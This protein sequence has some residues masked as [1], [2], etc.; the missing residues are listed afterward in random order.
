[1]VGIYKITSPSGKIYIGQSTNI[2][3]RFKEYQ[4]YKSSISIGSK[5]FKSFQKYGVENH[6]FEIIEECTLE[7]LNEREIYW[8]YYFNTLGKTGLN[9]RLGNANGI[10]SE[11]TKKKIGKGNKGKIKHLSGPKR[12][13][14]LQYD[15]QGNF[16]R[17][18]RSGKEASV[19]LNLKKQSICNNL[20]NRTKSAYN[21]IWRYKI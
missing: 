16:I 7:Q 2:E 4:I 14:I 3:R 17:E 13:P 21:F 19:S 15:L 9:L 5:L 20:K 10:C 12:I 6:T 11:E 1:M 18:W 8:G